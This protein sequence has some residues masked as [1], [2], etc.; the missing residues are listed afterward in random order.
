MG[1]LFMSSTI[2]P[3]EIQ[4]LL[5][6]YRNVPFVHN[7]RSIE[8]GLDCLGFVILF[9]REFGIELPNDDGKFIEKDWYK[10]DPNRFIRAIE[11]LNYPKVSPYELQPLDMV[12]FAISR[13]IITHTGVMINEY[14]FAHMSPKKGFRIDRFTLPWRRRFRGAIRLIDKNSP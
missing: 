11:S 10:R 8:K 3:K 14:E 7:G 4:Q 13:N 1:W 2:N 9:Y 5:T 12:Y 6:K